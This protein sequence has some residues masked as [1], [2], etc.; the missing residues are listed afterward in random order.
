MGRISK[1]PSAPIQ[2]PGRDQARREQGFALSAP[3]PGESHPVLPGK[4]SKQLLVCSKHSVSAGSLPLYRGVPVLTAGPPPKGLD[5]LSLPDGRAQRLLRDSP[6]VLND[7][8]SVGL[9]FY[10]FALD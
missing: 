5:W 2:A 7:L 6:L 3:V 10:I 8:G 1:G 4:S 9:H